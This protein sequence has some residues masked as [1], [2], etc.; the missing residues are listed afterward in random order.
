MTPISSNYVSTFQ[1]PNYFLFQWICLRRTIYIKLY[2]P[3]Y[4]IFHD[5]FFSVNIMFLRFICV[6]TCINISSFSL[7]NNICSDM[8]H[9]VYTTSYFC[10]LFATLASVGDSLEVLRLLIF[11]VAF[12]DFPLISL[13]IPPQTLSS[14]AL[15]PITFK[16]LMLFRQYHPLDSAMRSPTP[17]N[18]L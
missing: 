12:F 15:L 10:Y 3:I 2:H 18:I 17:N 1:L 7:L 11:A 16:L 13:A 4:V 5:W 9:F 6:M 8:L 14:N